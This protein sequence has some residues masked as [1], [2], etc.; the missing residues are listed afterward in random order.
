MIRQSYS[1]AAA[2]ERAAAARRTASARALGPAGKADRQ[3]QW[4]SVSRRRTPAVRA[5]RRA[6]DLSFRIDGAR[7][8]ESIHLCTSTFLASAAPSWADSP[9]SRA[10]QATR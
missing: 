1:I 4:R 8:R 3:L 6:A 5:V 2:P 9:C 7:R 10:R